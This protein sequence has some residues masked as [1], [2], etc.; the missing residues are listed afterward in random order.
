VWLG[1]TLW[2]ALRLE[3]DGDRRVGLRGV[4][5]IGLGVVAHDGAGQR[6]GPGAACGVQFAQV[7]DRLLHDLA[8]HADRAEV[9]KSNETVGIGYL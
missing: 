9:V 3:A 6:P 2:R 5:Q 8:P 7:G 1:W 4:E